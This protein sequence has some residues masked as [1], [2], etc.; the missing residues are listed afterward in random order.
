MAAKVL[1]PHYP[2]ESMK[3]FSFEIIKQDPK[4]KA[5]AGIMLKKSMETFISIDTYYT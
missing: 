2:N 5:K 1:K 3:D 4:S